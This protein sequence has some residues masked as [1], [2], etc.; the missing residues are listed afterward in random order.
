[1]HLALSSPFR[2][3][4][5][6]FFVDATTAESAA[7][8]LRNISLVKGIGNSRENAL[9]WL[10]RKNDEWLLVI[11]NADD[12]SLDLPN[13]FPD[14]SFG[15]IVISSRNSETC[16]HAPD[17]RSNSNVPYLTPEDANNFLF[18]VAGVTEEASEQTEMLARNFVKVC[19]TTHLSRYYR[20]DDF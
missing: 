9:Q 13:Y 18:K 4:S 19:H 11:N 14:G 16:A 5:D 20:F 8:D 12:P 7:S 1:M 10:S 17:P 15:N 6:V 2:R 3:F